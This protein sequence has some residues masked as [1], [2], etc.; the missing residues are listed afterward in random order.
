VALS[1][2]STAATAAAVAEGTAAQATPA[3]KP[4]PWQ[5]IP[6]LCCAGVHTVPHPEP[7]VL[8]CLSPSSCCSP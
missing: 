8:P 1:P 4:C 2:P 5:N 6:H 7:A 3:A